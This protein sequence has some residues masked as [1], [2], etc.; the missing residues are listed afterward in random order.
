M[1]KKCVYALVSAL[2][3][4]FWKVPQSDAMPLF[5]RK[6]GVTCNVC[7]TTTPLLNETGYKFRAAGYRMPKDISKSAGEKFEPGNYFSARSQAR[8]NVLGGVA[9]PLTTTS[10]FNFTEF[11]LYPLTSSW[12]KHFGSL[13]ELSVSLEDFFYI[14]NPYI[15]LT[16]GN[17][18][19]FFT[20]RVGIFHPGEG[21]GAS[22]RPFSNARPLFQAIPIS[23]GDRAVRYLFQPRGLDEAGQSRHRIH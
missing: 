11:T 20:P 5:A 2:I 16:S 3:L 10:S 13:A 19:K 9:G 21:F 14:E 1:R 22:D 18:K 7:H 6:L 4:I 23:S 15:R 8:A 17:G 12:G